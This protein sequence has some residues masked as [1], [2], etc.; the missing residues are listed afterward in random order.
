MKQN[1]SEPSRYCYCT[2][3]TNTQK[4]KKYQENAMSSILKES[5][6]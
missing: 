4:I 5:Y 2:I 6:T 3:L 1:F